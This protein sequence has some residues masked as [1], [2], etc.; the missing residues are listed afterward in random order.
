MWPIRYNF[1]NSDILMIHYEKLLHLLC[2]TQDYSLKRKIRDLIELYNWKKH[3]LDI[4]YE[5][6]SW[7]NCYIGLS[8]NDPN[9]SSIINLATQDSLEERLYIPKEIIIYSCGYAFLSGNFTM[10]KEIKKIGEFRQAIK[11]KEML[12][13]ISEETLNNILAFLETKQKIENDKKIILFEK[14]ELKVDD[15]TLKQSV[16][17]RKR[18]N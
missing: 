1:Y 14:N 8:I 17:Q 4:P 10:T 3:Y 18:V 9:N 12:E 15:V 5:L 2:I 16:Y 11:R 13:L 6:K 7:P